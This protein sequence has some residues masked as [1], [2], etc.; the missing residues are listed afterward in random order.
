M[1]IMQLPQTAHGW[2]DWSSTDSSKSTGAREYGDVLKI[3][4][5]FRIFQNSKCSLHMHL[6]LVPLTQ[7]NVAP[8]DAAI[9]ASARTGTQPNGESDKVKPDPVEWIHPSLW[10]MIM[11]S[12]VNI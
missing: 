4:H 5:S 7:G 3:R 10:W 1:K 2:I 8:L 6:Y 12:P 9:L 11:L